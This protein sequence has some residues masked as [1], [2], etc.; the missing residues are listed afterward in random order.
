M[1]DHHKVISHASELSARIHYN[2]SFRSSIS[3]FARISPATFLAHQLYAAPPIE[4]ITFR[5]AAVAASEENKHALIERSLGTV[6]A[7]FA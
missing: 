7:H 6:E 5:L 2:L 3:V 4:R 1:A